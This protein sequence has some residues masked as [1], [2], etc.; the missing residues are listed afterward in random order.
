MIIDPV[1]DFDKVSGRVS[2]ETADCILDFIERR[3]L[4]VTRIMETHAHAD[5]LTSSQYLKAKLGSRVPVCIGRRITKVQEM[6]APR[7]HVDPTELQHTF[8][9]YLED[10]EVFKLGDLEFQ[11]MHLPGHTPDHVAYRVDSCV[12]TGDSIFEPDVGSAR[13]DFPGGSAKDLY[14][15][16]RKLM[17]LPED[18]RLFVGHDYP[19]E[20]REPNCVSTVDMH[21]ATNKHINSTVDEPT[22]IRIRED[23]DKMLSAPR[24]L[25]PSLQV[26]IRGGRV[27]EKLVDPVSK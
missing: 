14:K 25:H 18:Y 8:D 9:I 7:Y 13:A 2:T 26:N 20:G 11:V 6:F 19:P 15:S 21:K 5:H 12:F 17:D 23:R 27:P 24:L 3:G 16:L 10:N 4:K 22:F 1:L